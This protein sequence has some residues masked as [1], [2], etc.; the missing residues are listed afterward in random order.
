MKLKELVGAVKA[1]I[2]S[3]EHIAATGYDTEY[4]THIDLRLKLN[5]FMDGFE[6]GIK[7]NSGIGR[8]EQA[9]LEVGEP[10]VFHS[11]IRAYKKRRD[12]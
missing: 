6:L 12:L 7:A 10:R 5:G 4:R 9:E 3:A 2:K 1:S 11:S 8:K